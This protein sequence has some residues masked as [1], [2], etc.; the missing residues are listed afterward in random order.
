MRK[1]F[2]KFNLLKNERK[3]RVRN[4]NIP[5]FH[6]HHVSLR[7]FYDYYTCVMMMMIISIFL[8]FPYYKHV[9]SILRINNNK[10]K[11]KKV[12]KKN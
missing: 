12:K 10:N 4:L 2:Y 3:I 7:I 6:T 9:E 11:I 5:N 1:N 8:N